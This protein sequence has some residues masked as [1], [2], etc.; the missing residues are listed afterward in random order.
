[1]LSRGPA[2]LLPV[3]LIASV[4]VCAVL[5]AQNTD[6]VNAWRRKPQMAQAKAADIVPA[7]VRASRDSFFDSVLGRSPGGGAV[8]ESAGPAMEVPPSPI[9]VVGRFTRFVTRLS[10]IRKSLYTEVHMDVEQVLQDKAGG[11][12]PGKVVTVILGGGSL[13]M[14]DGKVVRRDVEQERQFGIQP[15]HRYVLFL[16]RQQE[17]DFYTYDKSW[18]LTNGKAVPNSPDDA[19][20]AGKGTSRFAGMPEASFVD[21]MRSAVSGGRR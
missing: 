2:R 10:A 3:A 17:A 7:G 12:A 8:W 11:L 1:M 6:D 13:Q 21:A 9:V 20:R 5:S 18:E 19:V 4:A 14:P 16:S 15:G